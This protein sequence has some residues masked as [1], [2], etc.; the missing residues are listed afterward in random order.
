MVGLRGGNGMKISACVIVKNEE[1]NIGT[2]L[3][4]MAQ[5]AD[6]MIVVDTGSTDKTKEIVAASSAQL[7]EFPWIN[8][9]AAAKNFALSKAKGEWIA[10]L[11]ADEFFSRDSIPLIRKWLK[12]LHFQK[13]N[14]GVMCRLINID[15]GKNN[16]FIGSA[17]QLRL[18]RNKPF[19]KYVGAIHEALDVPKHCVVE[20]VDDLEIWSGIALLA[21]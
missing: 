9:F 1:K 17:V 7:Y 14:V 19:L 2:W 4:N 3:E 10:F 18:F 11:D 20:L 6:E 5:F 12:K 15:T 13:K 8:D 16:R 21:S